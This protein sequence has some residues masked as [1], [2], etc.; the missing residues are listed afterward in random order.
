MIILL[1]IGFG[2][3]V[4][5]FSLMTLR[6]SIRSRRENQAPLANQV[7]KEG[8]VTCTAG[9][10]V[11]I[12][13]L[14]GFYCNWMLSREAAILMGAGAALIILGIHALIQWV[15]QSGRGTEHHVY[16]GAWAATCFGFGLIIVYAILRFIGVQF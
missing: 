4:L 15:V 8:L 7:L 9:F 2:L 13:G 16:I 1:T 10:I 6:N 11:L 12:I 3:L 5:G 14:S